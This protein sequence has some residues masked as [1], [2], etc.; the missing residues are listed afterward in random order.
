MA[1]R[2]L[3]HIDAEELDTAVTFYMR[4]FGLVVG[5]RP[6]PALIELLGAGTPIHLF[7]RAAGRSSATL[8]PSRPPVEIDLVV[9]D[10]ESARER[11]SRAGAVLEGRVRDYDW[12]SIA[13]LNDPFGNRLCLLQFRRRGLRETAAPW[14]CGGVLASG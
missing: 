7:A 5:R 4:A 6:G 11:A 10:V 3:L 12:G 1:P 14:D 2:V 8:R 9:E 13:R